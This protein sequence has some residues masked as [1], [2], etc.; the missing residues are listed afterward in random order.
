MQALINGFR[1][2]LDEFDRLQTE[3]EE[4]RAVK[5]Q[6]DGLLTV[7]EIAGIL[8]DGVVRNSCRSVEPDTAPD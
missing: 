5:E 2:I 4:E 7:E 6:E 3:L 1:T 8:H